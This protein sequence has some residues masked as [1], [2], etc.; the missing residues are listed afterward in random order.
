MTADAVA[1]GWLQHPELA[2][3]RL[4]AA[5]HASADDLPL[6][7]DKAWPYRDGGWL[8]RARARGDDWWGLASLRGSD[9]PK[10]LKWGVS[11]GAVRYL[12]ADNVFAWPLAADPALALESAGPVSTGAH[13]LGYKPLYRCVLR[14]GDRTSGAWIAKLYAGDR[15]LRAAE[16]YA[17][18][19][20]LEEPASVV[21]P[22]PE[23]Y[24][25]PQRMLR[26]RVFDGESLL[27]SL[28]ADARPDL[29]KRAAEVIAHLHVR[30]TRWVRRHTADDELAT[31]A[32]W[33]RFASSVS[34]ALHAR[35]AKALDD[36][37]AAAALMPAGRYVPSHRDFYDK[38]ILV[39][40]ERSVLL[41]LDTACLAEPELDIGNFLAHL[42]LRELQGGLDG[43]GPLSV[44]FTRHYWEAGGAIDPERVEFYQACTHL[45]LACVYLARPQW[46]GLVGRLLDS[47]AP[48]DHSHTRK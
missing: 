46:T 31:V 3:S 33:V 25:R 36:L 21:I 18:L 20:D 34:P 43:A 2:A 45:R 27:Q 35:L 28:E 1:F 39:D 10:S 41:D 38:Q 22:R 30:N 19:G 40:G 8:A 4:A 37:Q 9:V 48:L 12:A 6:V 29:V 5:S 17:S 7:I 32:R 13:I 16:T 11:T 42:Q 47:I 23:Q 14:G 26:W 15:G 24:D 44:E